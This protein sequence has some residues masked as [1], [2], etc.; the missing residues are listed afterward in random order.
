MSS[1][2]PTLSEHSPYARWFSTPQLPEAFHFGGLR[3]PENLI[4]LDHAA[5]TPL[6]ARVLGAML[7]WMRELYGN[8]ANRL[9]PMGEVAEHGLALARRTVAEAIGVDFEEVV[10]CSSATEANNL[11]LR[12]L[13]E[14]PLRRRNTIVVSATEHSSV[15]TTL[16][17]LGQH[18]IR[19][20]TL[21]VDA[22]G[23]ISLESAVQSIDADTLAVC[24]MDVNNE[25]GIQQTKLN[26][27]AGIAREHGA[28]FHVDA[29][30][31]FARH[32]FHTGAT[33][34]D[35]A[36]L[37]G[38]K[39]Y[40][41]KGAAALIVRKKQPRIR[42]APQLTGGG[43]EGGLRS[44]TPNLPAIAGFAEGIRLQV[45]ERHDRLHY[46]SHLE[47]IFVSSLQGQI[48]ATVVGQDS[49][50]VPGIL[51]IRIANVNA[52]KLI[53]NM[54]IMCVSAGSAC[55]TLQATTSHVLKSMGLDEEEAL[56]SFRISIGLTNTEAEMSRS[57]H[58]IS[59]TSVEL[60]S[61]SAV[62]P[63]AKN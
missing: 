25:T 10:F 44:G 16:E 19:I 60:R 41:G 31:G 39:I 1:V 6:D 33:E 59:K 43:H 56:A 55:K 15:L 21:P 13:V 14:N 61:H 24:V 62:W 34:F 26:A 38:A 5:S 50:R 3:L 28:V 57:A 18:G 12:G 9:H 7:P 54:K 42:I 52:M 63:V 22:S 8:P 36:T 53:E 48:D 49:P 30:Q 27:I 45:L 51:T 47:S 11:V 46:L 58:L 4:Y 20:K 35:T 40:A 17:T 2:T 23:Q 29:V 37:S 32:H